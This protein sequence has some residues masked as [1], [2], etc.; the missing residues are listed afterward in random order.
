MALSKI[1]ACYDGSTSAKTALDLAADIAKNDATIAVDIVN[2]VAVP[3][4]TDEQMASFASVL[5]LMERDASELLSEAVDRLDEAG[6]EN[7]VETYTLNGT[8]AANEI[9][10]LAEQGN[11]DI[12]VIGSRGLGGI[13]GYLGSV[14][15]KLLS[16][17][18]KPMLVAK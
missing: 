5:D 14:G 12:V 10:K 3:L 17:C 16:I 8:D 9:A 7:P 1:L 6:L 13:K 2:V 15:H 18:S 4:L 11:Y